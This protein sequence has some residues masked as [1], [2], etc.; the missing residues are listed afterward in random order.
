VGTSV[1]TIVV[2]RRPRAFRLYRPAGLIEPAALV[3][4]LH[5]G[6]G[7]GRQAEAAYG[8]NDRADRDGF[9][10]AYPDGLDR[11]WNVGGGCCGQSG[12]AGVDDVAFIVAM[13]AQIRTTVPVDPAR[14]YATGMSNGGMFAYRLACDTELFAAV[15]PVAGTLLG[16][17]PAPAPVSLIH[18][19]GLAD[20][21][22]RYDG[23]PGEGVGRIDGPPVPE[24]IAS[25]RAV[26]GC[27]P[28]TVTTA[29]TVTRSVAACR[30][31]HAVVVVTIDD[32]GHEWPGAEGPVG[33]DATDAIWRFFTEHPRR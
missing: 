12:R 14:V 18:V 5:G 22:V 24:V 19:H 26:D 27:E 4:M 32:V 7:S 11:V 21:R 29:A 16:A 2:D 10:V 31:G 33:I 13:V 9:A 6:F 15:A 8:W 20:R 17:C 28:P 30:D 1:H 25:W 23:Q 3:V